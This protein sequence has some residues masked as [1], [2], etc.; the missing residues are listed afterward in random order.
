MSFRVIVC[1]DADFFHFL[2]YLEADITRK[3]GRP[4]DHLRP[5]PHPR[6]RAPR[7]KSEV[8]IIEVADAYR[9]SSPSAASS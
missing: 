2:P 5:R 6:A 8:V 4:A 1:A 9:A 3:F 7:L